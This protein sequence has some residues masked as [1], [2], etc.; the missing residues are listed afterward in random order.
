LRREN[1]AASTF[2]R[3]I[4]RDEA[5]RQG[6]PF[7]AE[8]SD[9]DGWLAGGQQESKKVFSFKDPARTFGFVKPGLLSL[10]DMR[11]RLNS[12]WSDLKDEKFLT[13]STILERLLTEAKA[14]AR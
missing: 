10:D 1:V 2:N 12:V 14:G 5:K 7:Q 6:Q 11:K 4:G 8:A 9:A 13:S 3:V